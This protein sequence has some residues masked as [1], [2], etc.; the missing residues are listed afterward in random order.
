MGRPGNKANLVYTGSY[1]SNFAGAYAVAHIEGE[2]EKQILLDEVA[3]TGEES[4]LVNCSHGGL[5]NHD[6]THPEDA[7]VVCQGKSYSCGILLLLS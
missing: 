6:C 3:C 4:R 2:E 7:G 5:H 1:L